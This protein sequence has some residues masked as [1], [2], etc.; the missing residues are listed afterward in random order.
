MTV[1]ADYHLSASALALGRAAPDGAQVELVQVLAGEQSPVAYFWV[2]E[3]PADQF[4]R[5]LAEQQVIEA[6]EPVDDIGGGRLY[7]G[8]YDVDRDALIEGVVDNDGV[9][10][11]AVGDD[12]EWDVLLRFPGPDA[13][14]SFQRGHVDDRSATVDGVYGAADPTTGADTEL[15]R[16]QRET[17]MT[18]YRQGYFDIPRKITLVDLAG[19]LGVSDQAVSERIRRGE[20]K[21]VRS[22]LFED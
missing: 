14:R 12:E 22:Q 17:L 11:E 10:L 1:I 21:L 3:G 19:E 15:T 7:R 16:R 6:V 8:R 9:V 13:F 2:W 4:E 5:A 20:A 18:A